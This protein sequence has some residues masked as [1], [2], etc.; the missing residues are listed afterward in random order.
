VT[1]GEVVGR[2]AWVGNPVTKKNSQTVLALARDASGKKRRL[3]PYIHGVLRALAQKR[4]GAAV[5][6]LKA[7]LFDGGLQTIVLPAPDY[8]AMVKRVAPKLRAAWKAKHVGPVG[9]PDCLIWIEARFVLGPRQRPDLLGLMEA[10][11]DLLQA[12][13]VVTDDRWLEC[14]D[15]TRCIRN[16]RENPRTEVIL[17]RLN[18]ERGGQ[19]CIPL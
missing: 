1:Q 13:E 14:W 6:D 18:E 12:A 5:A 7:A 15:L 17:R 16:D 4:Y 10:V 9:G 8:Q 3:A 19:A 11:A 2:I